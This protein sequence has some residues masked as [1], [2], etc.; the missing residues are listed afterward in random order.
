MHPNEPAGVGT[1]APRSAR[2]VAVAP[3]LAIVVGITVLRGPLAALFAGPVAGTWVT[4]MLS[5]TVQAL[6]FLVLGVILSSA[7][8][9]FVPSERLG[10]LIPR[11]TGLAVPMAS[12]AGVALPGC[13]CGSVVVAGRLVTAGVPPGPAVAFLLAAPA[14]NPVVM[15]AT[16]IAF[17]GQPKVV[18]ARFVA[19]LATAMVVG[20]VWSR[21]V[22]ATAASSVSR[23]APAIA[24]KGEPWAQW[25]RFQRTLVED[26][27]HAGGFLVV[28]AMA[29]ATLRVAVRPDALG[30]LGSSR[31]AGV[32][33]LA[34]MA[35]LL[36]VCSEADAFVAASLTQF[37]MTARLA[38]M[39]V[40]PVV[41]VKLVALH[42]ATFGPS[43]A[44]R[45][46]PLVLCTAVAAAVVV[47]AWVA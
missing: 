28:G 19:S 30:S 5:V 9:A 14:V 37:S 23:P 47:G 22:G 40:G 45:F 16:A 46:E 12:I 42:V 6:P 29:T 18:L 24:S 34:V 41:D 36:C 13:E 10:R 31:P 11:R 32:I 38:F 3:L 21:M 1:E 17:P 44:V 15:V 2:P 25:I 7:I 35:V 39:V 8:V 4:I 33:A 27:L 26:V 43:F 20:L